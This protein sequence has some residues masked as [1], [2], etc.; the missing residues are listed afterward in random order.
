[1]TPENSNRLSS[2]SPSES[3]SSTICST[4]CEVHFMP[5]RRMA[6]CNSSVLTVP[7]P[8]VSS[9]RKARRYS[10]IF[11][12]SGFSRLLLKISL[13]LSDR[14]VDVRFFGVL[15]RR[16]GMYSSIHKLPF[17]VH[18]CEKRTEVLVLC[19]RF[20]PSR[21]GRATIQL[22]WINCDQWKFNIFF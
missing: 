11:H 9:L 10:S 15:V 22:L 17:Q 13:S 20:A 12:P 5:I 18:P 1:M 14:R 3:P 19:F 6:A 21:K 2:R 8:S 16:R 7:D 4:S